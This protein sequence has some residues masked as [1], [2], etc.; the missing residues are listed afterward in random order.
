MK[1]CLISN[2]SELVKAFEDTHLFE[3][4]SVYHKLQDIQDED[5]IIISDDLVSQNELLA[6]LA[7]YGQD[8]QHIYYLLASFNDLKLVHNI[9]S[10][11]VSRGIETIPPKQTVNQIVNRIVSRFFPESSDTSMVAAF[12]GADS[13][14]G[15]TMIAQ[16]VAEAISMNTCQKVGLFFLNKKH[17]LD[18]INSNV[19]LDSLKSKMFNK[20]LG[21][22]ELAEFC[23]KKGNLFILPG[24]DNMLEQRQY[25]PEHVEILLELSS[26]FVDVIIIDAGSDIDNGLS[27]GA[28][29]SSNAKYLVTTQQESAKIQFNRMKNQI[30]QSLQIKPAEF[31]GVINKY[32]DMPGAVKPSELS[33]QYS[34][35]MAGVIPYMG[36]SGYQAEYERKT[37]Y[38]FNR[39]EMN[40]YRN[41][42]NALAKV[43]SNQLGFPFEEKEEGA[44]KGLLTR[45]FPKVG[46]V[47]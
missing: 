15:T 38:S 37:F 21:P 3:K 12:L 20:L 24:P 27:L 10:I 26:E 16:S 14:V 11:C 6:Y 23:I 45:L 32:V 22:E 25:T 1:I 46:G 19:T 2:S 28:L 34:F 5:A 44:K 7:D 41:Q 17:S 31:M 30:F 29:N 42:I 35:T 40:E 13:K 43:M 9:V 47:F 39:P 36:L 33:D 18:F 4:I 8:N